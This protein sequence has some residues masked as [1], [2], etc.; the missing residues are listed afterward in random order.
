MTVHC[1][2]MQHS[3][4]FRSQLEASINVIS[5]VF[6]RPTVPDEAVKARDPG[7]NRS[8]EILYKPS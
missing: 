8:E 2:S 3:V 7:L 5:G 4:A 6:V 1:T